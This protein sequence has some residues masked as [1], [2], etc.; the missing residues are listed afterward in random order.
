MTVGTDAPSTHDR[1]EFERQAALRPHIFALLLCRFRRQEQIWVL[2]KLANNLQASRYSK[3]PYT[4]SREY[5]LFVLALAILHLAATTTLARARVYL[6][7]K[8]YPLSE[9]VRSRLQHRS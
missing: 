1:Q 6:R 3:D 8:S 5:T 9:F 4:A 7:K 2:G